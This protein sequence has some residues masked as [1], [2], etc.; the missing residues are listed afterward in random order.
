MNFPLCSQYFMPIPGG[1]A[2]ILLELAARLAG[3]SSRHPVET[4]IDATVMTGTTETAPEDASLPP[5]YISWDVIAYSGTR[6]LEP[7]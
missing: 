1:V 4:S 3:W 2:S 7:R 6:F 5:K